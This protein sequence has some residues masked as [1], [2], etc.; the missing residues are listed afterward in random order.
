MLLNARN[1]LFS[2][3]FPR[4]FVPADIAQKYKPYLNRI[5]G[6][7]IEEPVDFINYTI[8]GCNF[9]S[10]SQSPVETMAR[11]STRFH[12]SVKPGVVDDKTF[13]ITMQL[14]DGYVNYWIMRDLFTRYYDHKE[15][16]E[17]FLEDLALNITDS[18]GNV[19]VTVLMMYPIMLGVGELS[20][21]FASNVA[22]FTTFDVAFQ[23][24]RLKLDNQITGGSVNDPF[25]NE[26]NFSKVDEITREAESTGNVAF[27]K[28]GKWGFRDVYGSELIPPIHKSALE[29]S[30]E[31]DKLLGNKYDKS[32]TTNRLKNIDKGS[33]GSGNYDS[34]KPA[35]SL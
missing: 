27:F 13:T 26:D 7:V 3:N 8:Q 15:T 22:E 32:D 25:F 29:A 4:N 34:D 20:M 19:I 17:H 1:N 33:D 12:R 24:N 23:Y 16:R 18:E 28:S 2:F 30:N 10:V 14:V 21:S 6:N 35:F 5:P 31:A 9:P 11:G